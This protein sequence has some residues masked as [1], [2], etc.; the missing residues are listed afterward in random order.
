MHPCRSVIGGGQ[1]RRPRAVIEP[2]L[3]NGC[4]A[5]LKRLQIFPRS[6]TGWRP[7]IGFVAWITCYSACVALV[8]LLFVQSPPRLAGLRRESYQNR[9]QPVLLTHPSLIQVRHWLSVLI[10]GQ[11]VGVMPVYSYWYYS[12]TPR[13]EC[14]MIFGMLLPKLTCGALYC[15][16]ALSSPPIMAHTMELLGGGRCRRRRVSTSKSVGPTCP[17]LPLSLD[18][19]S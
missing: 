1:V 2:R 12:S 8:L 13:I 17:H 6:C 5:K 15:C 7:T 10:R 4:G 16:G 19:V 9:L 11:M 14:G 3:L 18:Q